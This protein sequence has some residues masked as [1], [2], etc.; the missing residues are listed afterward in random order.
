MP[1]C[2]AGAHFL[3]LLRIVIA[4]PRA[5]GD[6]SYHADNRC[7]SQAKD[8]AGGA[9]ALMEGSVDGAPYYLSDVIAEVLDE[10]PILAEIIPVGLALILCHQL[11]RTFRRRGQV[12]KKFAANP[13]APKK[14]SDFEGERRSKAM[15]LAN[16][17]AG[18]VEEFCSE[19]TGLAHFAAG[20]VEQVEQSLDPKRGTAHRSDCRGARI[21]AAPQTVLNL[22]VETRPEAMLP[23]SATGGEV[24][25]FEPVVDREVQISPAGQIGARSLAPIESDYVEACSLPRASLKPG[26]AIPSAPKQALDIEGDTR[27]EAMLSADVAVGVVDQV[28]QALVRDLCRLQN[29]YGSSSSDELSKWAG[30]ILET[31]PEKFVPVFVKFISDI[32]PLS[33]ADQLGYVL[34]LMEAAA[35]VG[36][37]DLVWG[38]VVK[39][40][41]RFGLAVDR[42]RVHEALR[43]A[44]QSKRASRR[45]FRH[46]QGNKESAAIPMAPQ[47]AQEWGVQVLPA[48][49]FQVMPHVYDQMACGFHVPPYVYDQT[50]YNQITGS[51]ARSRGMAAVGGIAADMHTLPPPMLHAAPPPGLHPAAPPGLR[52]PPPPGL[53]LRPPP[54][55]A[56]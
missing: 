44:N 38:F 48:S 1:G 54:G 21:Q 23:A 47:K 56:S 31:Y 55:L 45:Q 20:E 35:L 34:I 36:R 41:A 39:A 16:A 33:P 29:Q 40:E 26:D 52:P 17:A 11:R 7:T 46:G 12:N 19:A 24:E 18:E 9:C 14:A 22:E 3:C 15:L 6:T 10:A 8:V 37:R 50:A 2:Y 13:M 25:Q 4:D 5:T 51:C 28:E 27:P 43:L 53:Q 32:P 30:R 49:A 42:Q